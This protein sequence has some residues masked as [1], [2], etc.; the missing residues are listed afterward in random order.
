[1]EGFLHIYFGQILSS[2]V[3][4]VAAIL[5]GIYGKKFENTVLESPSL[6]FYY[7]YIVYFFFMSGN[8][9]AVIVSA[10]VRN[11]TNLFLLYLFVKIIKEFFWGTNDRNNKQLGSV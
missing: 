7:S 5:Y 3:V 1:M 8:I 2:I 11:F 10:V 4:F 9:D 6:T